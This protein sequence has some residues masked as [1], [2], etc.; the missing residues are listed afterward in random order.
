MAFFMS[1]A[2]RQ[3]RWLRTFVGNPHGRWVT[4]QGAMIALDIAKQFAI[5]APATNFCELTFSPL[6]SGLFAVLLYGS[7]NCAAS[8]RSSMGL[9]LCLRIA[10]DPHLAQHLPEQRVRGHDLVAAGQQ[11][12]QA[13]HLLAGTASS[14]AC[15]GRMT[16]CCVPVAASCWRR[17]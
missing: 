4:G 13:R 3:K 5:R 16:S 14:S 7:G 17:A 6:L 1:D 9:V 15:V 10:P 2:D 11:V 12:L 8:P